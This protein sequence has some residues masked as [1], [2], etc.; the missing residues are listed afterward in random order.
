MRRRLL[1]SLLALGALCWSAP[2]RAADPKVELAIEPAAASAATADETALPLTIIA[3]VASGWHINANRPNQAFLV[4]TALTL[5]LPPGVTADPPSYPEPKARQFAFAGQ[6]TLLVYEG[7]VPVTTTLHVPLGRA[8]EPLQVEAALRYQACDDTTCLPPAT[9]R[10]QRDLAKHQR[11]GHGTRDSG[12]QPLG[13]ILLDPSGATAL[14]GSDAAGSFA[15]LLGEH[16]L[17]VTL[18]AMAVLGLGLNLTPCV[19]PLISV[20]IAY[21]GGQ[22]RRRAGTALLA[23][24]YVLG[25]ATSFSA[26]GLLAALSGGILGAALQ[27]RAVVIGI[28][29]L[30][31]LLALGSFGVYQIRPPVVLLRL[32][33]G[34]TAG[35]AGAL[36]M[37]LTMG[38]VAAPCVGPILAGL[39]VFVGSRQD[40]WLGGALFFCL[41]LGM[42][43]P[44]VALALAAG[45]LQ[46]L[47]RSGEWL[48]WTEHVFGCVLLCLAVY[49]LVPLLAEP[50]AG[51]VLP[52]AVAASGVYLGF[53]DP[54]GRSRPAFAA[55]RA[56]LGVLALA[57]AA[58]AVR[59]AGPAE[60]IAWELLATKAAAPPSIAGAGP[61][62]VEFGAEWCI[63][64]RQMEAT[65]YVDPA[66]VREATRFRMLR[67]D[68]TEENEASDALSARYGVT[69]V[70]TVILFAAGGDEQRRLVGYI[71]AEEMLTAMRA[72]R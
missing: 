53:L 41:A 19:Y 51:W 62:L 58:W 71:S 35:A 45:S 34:S 70:P 46:R 68:L 38:V 32:A 11:D 7:A 44:Y 49:Y 15:A 61:V 27:Q 4:P 65:T 1:G 56:T 13:A 66:V 24:L 64:C 18:L 72:V 37:G 52:A 55:L 40:V 14:L 12:S 9:A 3:T 39:M 36:F 33:G 50:M 43:A 57:F 42:G 54:A 8:D 20:T 26:L 2:G 59:P 31:V 25:I 21:F 28:A 69:G 22:A 6:A 23:A 30:L 47:P 63:P 5:T 10:A 60:S 17:L 48:L 16:G 29:A 67:A